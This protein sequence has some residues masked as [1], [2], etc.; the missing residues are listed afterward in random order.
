[1]LSSLCLCLPC[2]HD[3]HWHGI[4]SVARRVCLRDADGPTPERVIS[5]SANLCLSVTSNGK[6]TPVEGSPFTQISGMMVGTTGS[7]FITDGYG[8]DLTGGQLP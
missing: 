3:L 4:G 7:H 6:V 8:G 2:V 1:M 5:D